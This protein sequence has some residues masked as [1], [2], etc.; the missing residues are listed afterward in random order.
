MNKFGKP[1]EEDFETVRDVV[2]DMIRASPGLVLAR[3]QC[4]YASRYYYIAINQR[5]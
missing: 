1:T 2:K 3:S 5:S 4:N